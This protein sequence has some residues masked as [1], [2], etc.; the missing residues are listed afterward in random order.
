MKTAIL[1]CGLPGSGKTTF[2]HE[3]LQLAFQKYRFISADLLKDNYVGGLPLH[4]IHKWSINEARSLVNDAIKNK[5]DLL[6]D[7]GGINSNYTYDMVTN[8]IKES[9]DVSMYWI[10]TPV[11]VCIERNAQRTRKIPVPPEEI[12]KKSVRQEKCID[13]LITLTMANSGPGNFNFKRVPYFTRKHILCDMDGTVAAIQRLP[14][15]L[16]GNIDFVNG[17]VFRL[18]KPVDPVINRL[19]D[20]KHMSNS[21]IYILSASPNSICSDQKIEW[22]KKYMPF[23]ER[24]DIYFVGNKDYKHVM[25]EGLMKSRKLDPKDCSVVDDWNTFLCRAEQIGVEAIH[26]SM[27]LTN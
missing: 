11:R 9:Y 19:R 3:N 22:V 18:S 25:L 21:R 24:E 23:V 17:D 13:R 20:L 16:N 27:L 4:E 1:V 26:P 12:I 7:S 8:L 14:V 15:D 5:F 6:I 2:I 10:D